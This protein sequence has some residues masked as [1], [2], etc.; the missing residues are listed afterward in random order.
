[1]IPDQSPELKPPAEVRI[2]VLYASINLMPAFLIFLGGMGSA[3]VVGVRV[4]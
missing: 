1:M 2:I 3:S 4:Q